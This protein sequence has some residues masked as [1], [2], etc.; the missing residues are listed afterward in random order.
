MAFPQ[1]ERRRIACPAVGQGPT[2]LSTCPQSGAGRF[3]PTGLCGNTRGSPGAHHLCF[4][5]KHLA[6]TTGLSPRRGRAGSAEHKSKNQPQIEKERH[7]ARGFVSWR[8]LVPV[9]TDTEGA[10]RG[11]WPMWAGPGRTSQRWGFRASREIPAVKPSW[12]AEAHAVL[13]GKVHN[14]PAQHACRC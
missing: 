12:M 6:S 14:Q 1:E 4:C 13:L 9:A 11:T 8:M 10:G 3:I 2:P 7:H 5:P